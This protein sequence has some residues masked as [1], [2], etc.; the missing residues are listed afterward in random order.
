MTDEELLKKATKFYIWG[1]ENSPSFN[2][3]VEL[4]SKDR[5]DGRH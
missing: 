2:L 1:V 3:C 4:K 5:S